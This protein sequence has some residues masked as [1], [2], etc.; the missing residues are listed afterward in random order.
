MGRS[1]IPLVTH[2][3]NKEVKAE[4]SIPASSIADALTLMAQTLAE[5]R[6]QAPQ[7]NTHLESLAQGVQALVNAESLRPHENRFDPGVSCFNP[8]G[9]AKF[10]RPDLKCKMIWVGYQLRKEGLTKP[11]I[12]ALNAAQPGSY[13]VTKSD[14][15]TV[16]F[17]VAD[18]VDLA[19]KLEK[20]IFHFPCKNTEDRQNHMPMLSYLREA[21]GD[22]LPSVEF[23]LAQV[24]TLK[25]ELAVQTP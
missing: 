6:R 1:H 7:D 10:P 18:T 4:E 11:E 13:R 17:T 2:M 14:G 25:A 20:R 19:G 15:R 3:A 5:L 24:E 8:L 16:P 12:D 23:L 9:E 22:I 21:A